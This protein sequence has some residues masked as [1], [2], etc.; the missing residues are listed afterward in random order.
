MNKDSI[1]Y[2]PDT[3]AKGDTKTDTIRVGKFSHTG[4]YT[5]D[6]YFLKQQKEIH[7]VNY[8]PIFQD[9]TLRYI[10]HQ[11]IGGN[12]LGY[13]W[14][15]TSS[16]QIDSITR[17]YFYCYAA[18]K[19]YVA[20]DA[21]SLLGSSS[22]LITGDSTSLQMV[23]KLKIAFEHID[24]AGFKTRIDSLESRLSKQVDSTKVFK[25]SL[26]MIH[27]D[28]VRLIV[29]DSAIN[30]NDI[31]MWSIRI[32]D[33][34]LNIL[35]DTT[36]SAIINAANKRVPLLDTASQAKMH[37][38]LVNLYT[39]NPDKVFYRKDQ[40]NAEENLLLHDP[41][42]ER[43]RSQLWIGFDSN[44]EISF[45]TLSTRLVGPAKQ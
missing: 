36:V 21:S 11:I 31:K 10:Y 5:L 24:P 41:G 37:T 19:E 43:D 34:V 33:S 30:E 40:E 26:Y 23:S 22:N 32:I 35:T 1:I 9:D 38:Y 45:F 28:F 13:Y 3:L 6:Y 39:I 29:G 17:N 44:K 18:N 25:F 16:N 15:L 12:Y 8:R 2:Y 27:N 4:L 20:G 7:Y 14:N 42:N